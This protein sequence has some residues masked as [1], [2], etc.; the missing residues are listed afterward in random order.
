MKSRFYV[1]C[2]VALGVLFAL[3]VVIDI[4]FPLKYYGIIKKYC[5]SYGVRPSVALA[6][7]WAESKF[8]ASA[9]SNAGACGLMQLMPSTAE[10]LCSMTGQKYDYDSLFDAEY[11]VRLG[12]YYISYLQNSFS[13]K[14]VFAAYNAGEGNVRRWLE[15]NGEIQFA[16]TR[17]YVKRV[18]VLTNIYALRISDTP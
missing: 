8:D 11:N 17:N 18:S 12:V 9:V 16:E 3:V 7:I 14:Y 1:G 15:T 4:I 2:S 10:W 5:N 6:V 13:G